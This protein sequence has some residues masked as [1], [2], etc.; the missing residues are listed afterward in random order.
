MKIKCIKTE[1]LNKEGVYQALTIGK[2]YT[3]LSIEFYDRL[4]ST[5]SNSLGDF[6]AY[7]LKDNDGIVIPYP[8]KLFNITSGELPSCW[9]SYRSGGWSV[10]NAF[11]HSRHTMS[12]F[13]RFKPGTYQRE[14][15]TVYEWRHY[16]GFNQLS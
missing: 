15:P 5:F 16:D 3:V 13:S 9:V 4:E 2:E 6:I 1:R 12:P 7:R 11:C 8:S 10:I 14:T